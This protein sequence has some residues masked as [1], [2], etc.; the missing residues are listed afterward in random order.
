MIYV[1]LNKENKSTM[2]HFAPFH[3][4]YGL[5]KTESELL[6]E[7]ILVESLPEVKQVAGKKEVLNYDPVNKSLYYEYVDVEPEPLDPDTQIAQLKE[8]QA[9]SDQMNAELLFDGMM[10]E[11]RIASLEEQQAT[12][13]FQLIEG[14][15]I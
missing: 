8:Q 15:V 1:Q 3:E 12:L 7:G 11:E 10:K 5:G 6:S 2:Q 4:Q 13:I 14:G 9:I